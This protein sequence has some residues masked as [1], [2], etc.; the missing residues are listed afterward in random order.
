MTAEI[1]ILNSGA[2]ALAADSAMTWSG[3]STPKIYN[4]VNKLFTLSKYHPV[5]VMVYGRAELLG[6][7]WE[8]IIKV[9]R[10]NAGSQRFDTLEGYATNFIEFLSNNNAL[11]PADAQRTHVGRTTALYFSDLKKQIDERAAELADGAGLTDDQI[12]AIATEV[13]GEALQQWEAAPFLVSVDDQSI[14]LARVQYESVVDEAIEAVFEAMPRPPELRDHLHT[15]SANLFSR[16]LYTGPT[17]GVVVA[18]FGDQEFLPR[19]YEYAVSG[20]IMGQ[21]RYRPG[22]T[23]NAATGASITP[24]AQGEMVHTFMTGMNP[25]IRQLV[26]A[27]LE[28]VMG[29]LPDQL[30]IALAPYLTISDDDRAALVGSL[31]TICSTIKASV[32]DLVAGYAK[33]NHIDP[34]MVAVAALPK[35]QLAEM[36]ESLVNLTSFQQKV[37]GVTETVGG[38]IDVAVISKGDGFVWIKRK[39]YFQ[40][41]LNQQF[42]ANYY[43]QSASDSATEEGPG[44]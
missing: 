13:I 42:F 43:R 22:R 10:H 23:A 25:R 33:E 1:A 9:Y 12:V 2:I 40:P 4:T 30:A 8:T 14:A 3:T 26:G 38:P 24:F 5:G 39:H 31:K 11:F 35:D 7:P 32:E 41:G 6:V 34:V 19:L 20:V 17:S 36:A 28:R 18:G 27:H 21:L 29:E 16:D 44:V 37:S 15:L